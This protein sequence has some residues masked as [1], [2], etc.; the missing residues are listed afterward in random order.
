MAARPR[1]GSPRFGRSVAPRDPPRKAPEEIG[2][3][4]DVPLVAPE[5]DQIVLDHVV[6]RI[7]RLDRPGAAVKKLR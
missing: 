7:R 6:V 4:N 2:S 1:I 3:G 5:Q